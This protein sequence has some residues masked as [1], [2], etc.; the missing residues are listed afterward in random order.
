MGITAPV[1]QK[2]DEAERPDE[3]VDDDSRS[4]RAFVSDARC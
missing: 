1:T 2:M 3:H 4:S